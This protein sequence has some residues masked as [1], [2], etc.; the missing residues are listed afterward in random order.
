MRQ[1][2]AR[3]LEY[4]AVYRA[5]Q[6]PF[7]DEKFA[8]VARAI[9]RRPPRRVLDVGC[10]PGTNAGRFASVPYVGLDINPRYL[11]VA[12]G[13]HAGT[14]LCADLATADL[15]HLG[16]FDLVLINSFLHHLPD[17][18]VQMLLDRLAPRLALD[19]RL[20][21]LE[22]VRPERLSVPSLMA[23]L[24]RGRHARSLAAWRALLAPRFAIEAFTPYHFG[25]GW[26]AM[27]H[28]EGRRR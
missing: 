18:Q 22:L 9:A 2:V 23:A 14:F 19:G 10:G 7:A 4:P 13:R 20:H 25:F 12:R 3:L 8:P 5:W 16:E 26:W 28:V 1:I 21:L 11:E 27:V 6:A 24:D 15:T 17:D